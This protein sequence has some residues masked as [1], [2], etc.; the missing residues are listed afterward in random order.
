MGELNEQEFYAD[1]VQNDRNLSSMIRGIREMG[2]ASL[3]LERSDPKDIVSCPYMIM[4]TSR[5]RRWWDVFIMLMTIVSSVVVPRTPASHLPQSHH[6]LAAPHLP[7]PTLQ[8]AME[9]QQPRQTAP[10]PDHP[11]PRPCPCRCL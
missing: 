4:P 3:N 10:P 11:P 7:T 6:C 1:L 8:S 5:R 2:N 9:P